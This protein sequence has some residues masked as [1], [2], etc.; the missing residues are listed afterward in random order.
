[1]NNNHVFSVDLLSLG[2][3]QL[4]LNSRVIDSILRWFQPADL[5]TYPPLPVFDFGDGLRLT[6]GHTRAYVAYRMGVKAIP[7]VI[8]GSVTAPDTP[9]GALFEARITWSKRH[10]LKN[11]SD[12]SGR[13]L[14]DTAY[15]R[16]W[17]QRCER[18]YWL[19]TQRTGT[20]PLS[21]AR[22][23]EGFFLYG[24][25]QNLT[26]YYYEDA[27]GRLYVEQEGTLL[28]E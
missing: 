9:N 23:A 26:E 27:A 17:K 21:P 15:Q 19:L 16:L 2:I 25:N 24:S 13:V 5:G 10:Q 11:V 18:A 12:L 6:D 4:Y 8:D 28:P 3:T 1:M 22:E 20:A 7:V 14:S